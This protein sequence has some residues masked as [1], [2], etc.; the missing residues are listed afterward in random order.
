M[1]ALVKTRPGVGHVQL[2][3]MPEPNL[4]TDHAVRIEV[5]F[6]G[7]CGTDLHVYHDTFRN[8]PPVILG[9]EFSGTVREVGPAV[10]AVAV[11][12]RVTV[13]PASAVVCGECEFCRSGHYMFCPVRRGMG[14]GVH[15]SLTR[16]VVVREDQVYRLPDGIS[17]EAAALTEPFA[18]AWQAI[19]ELTSFEPGETVLLSGP[20]PIGLL[21][22]LALRIKG[23]RVIVAGT[24]QDAPRLEMAQRLGAARVVNVQEEDLQARVVQETGGRGADCVV[25]AAGS[26]ASAAAC[27]QAVRRLGQYVQVGIF[28]HDVTLPFD[29]ILYKQLR[30]FGSVGHS[31]RTWDAVMRLMQEGRLDLAP[32]ISHRL[33]LSQWREAFDLCEHK[34]GVKVLLYADEGLSTN[35]VAA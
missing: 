34:Q 31:R 27:L 9:H 33:P 12:D 23:C 3:S 7:I 15:G 10:T 18:A 11:G 4:P 13:C 28:G 14:H 22:L 32:L 1:Q 16:Y 25:E 6:T 35:E 29:T 5:A 17:L 21:C 19:D 26:P 24:T 8:Y 30:V 2:Q 20:G